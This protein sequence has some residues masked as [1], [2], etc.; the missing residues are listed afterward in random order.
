MTRKQVMD[1][2]TV[3]VARIKTGDVAQRIRRYI[4][5]VE[6]YRPQGSL[7]EWQRLLHALKRFKVVDQSVELE[8]ELT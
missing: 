2:A 6:V 4:R 7:P 3:A 8:K 1:A 5:L